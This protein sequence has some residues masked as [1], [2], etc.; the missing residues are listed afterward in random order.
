MRARSSGTGARRGGKAEADEGRKG[1][2]AGVLG[3]QIRGKRSSET[4]SYSSVSW[5]TPTCTPRRTPPQT[6]RSELIAELDML[7]GHLSVGSERERVSERASKRQTRSPFILSLGL[8]LSRALTN[9]ADI[10]DMHIRLCPYRCMCTYR[11][12][13][14]MYVLHIDLRTYCTRMQPLMPYPQFQEEEASVLVR[15]IAL[16]QSH[17]ASALRARVFDRKGVG[18]DGSSGSTRP[19]AAGVARESCVARGGGRVF[20]GTLQETIVEQSAA[21]QEAQ[22]E[23][24][25][26]LELEIERQIALDQI[27]KLLSA[28]SGQ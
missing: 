25:R 3:S 15:D 7:L 27:H 4:S 13:T 19:A 22:R 6:P 11:R 17:V 28:P 12:M 5:D 16:S 23:L 20:C 26:E 8:T 1:A 24:E 14:C 21:D 18:D 2:A 9:L 10:H